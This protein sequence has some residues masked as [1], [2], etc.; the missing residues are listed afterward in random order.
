M[1][2][3]DNDSQNDLLREVAPKKKKPSALPKIIVILVLAGTVGFYMFHDSE[4][5]KVVAI[6]KVEA[7]VIEM[8]ANP[9][10]STVQPAPESEPVVNAPAAKIIRIPG[11]SAR[12]IIAK[13]KETKEPADLEQIFKSAQEFEADAMLADA[14]L[15]YFFAARQ[16]HSA[17]AQVLAKMHDPAYHSKQ[18]S[19]MDEPDLAQAYKWYRQAAKGNDATAKKDLNN[20]RAQVEQLAA[21]GNIEAKQLSFQWQ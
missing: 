1:N 5:T 14:H 20:F 21:S 13:T 11:S 7:P 17:A 18:T 15:L 9:A 8:T 16:G 19:I 10:S 2:M 12:A 6:P 4:P 3:A